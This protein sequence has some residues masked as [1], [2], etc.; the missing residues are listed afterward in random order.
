MRNTKK[1]SSHVFKHSPFLLSYTHGS[2][3]STATNLGH[4]KNPEVG[5]G[6]HTDSLVLRNSPNSRG[7]GSPKSDANCAGRHPGLWMETTSLAAQERTAAGSP[8]GRARGPCGGDA[9]ASLRLGGTN[10]SFESV[11][12]R[13]AG[14]RSPCST[15]AASTVHSRLPRLLPS[16]VAIVCSP[17]FPLLS[18]GMDS[19]CSV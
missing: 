1:I 19:V 5:H 2:V 14:S 10:V 13:L 4:T 17:A 8:E 11:S 9:F 15:L 6:R 3:V 12:F 16:V 18:D 7:V